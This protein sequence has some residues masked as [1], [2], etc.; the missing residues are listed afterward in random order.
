[1]ILMM[2][3]DSVDKERHT[4]TV[5]NRLEIC[6][7]LTLLNIGEFMK[8]WTMPGRFRDRLGD[9]FVCA[10]WKC[11]ADQFADVIAPLFFEFPSADIGQTAVECTTIRMYIFGSRVSF[12]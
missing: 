7:I 3:D 2:C 8:L 11:V 9:V 10:L 4:W 1:M 5:V 12:R 6:E